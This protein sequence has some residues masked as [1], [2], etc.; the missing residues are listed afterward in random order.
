MDIF[1][2]ALISILCIIL[3]LSTGFSLCLSVADE[4]ETNNYFFSA[5][6]LLAES[7]YNEEVKASL[8][9]DA[10]ERGYELTIDIH[11]SGKAG[12]YKYANVTLTYAFKID[13]FDITLTRVKQRIV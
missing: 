9:A 6:Q 4:I 3:L 11:D 2:K 7:N 5:T 12:A 10:K 1:Y 8:I 13:L